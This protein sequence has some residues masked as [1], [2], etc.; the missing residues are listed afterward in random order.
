M[1]Y[2]KKEQ[3]AN[4]RNALLLVGRRYLY[5]ENKAVKSGGLFGALFQG[6]IGRKRLVGA[7]LA[8]IAIILSVGIFISAGG[9]LLPLARVLLVI[10]GV[11]LILIAVQLVL[12][13]FVFGEDTPNFFR[14][15]P[16][17]GRNLP[18]E[19]ITPDVVN[20]RMDT[21]FSR[22]AKSKG[23]LWLPGYLEKCNFGKNN[24]LRTVAAYKMLLD[25]AEVDSEGGWKC[26]VSCAPATVLWIA[27]ALKGEEPAMMK[28]VVFIKSKFGA[29]PSKIRNCLKKNE[30]Y[31]RARM[32]QFVKANVKAFD[33]MK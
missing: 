18:V 1:L 13:F 11:V 31:L 23:Q 20:A 3:E 22:I 2:C 28:D 19:K 30:P 14:Y 8:L 15:D 16:S 32:T 5:M 12:F 21:Y 17:I 10:S 7:I 25:L 24:A 9:D 4:R 6:E 26:F 29:D 27:D 33:G